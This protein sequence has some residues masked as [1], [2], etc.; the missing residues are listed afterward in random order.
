M[1]NRMRSEAEDARANQI[2]EQLR[3]LKRQETTPAASVTASVLGMISRTP[4]STSITSS[5]T[6]SVNC[7]DYDALS[8][9]ALAANI[10]GI[11][12]TGTPVDFQRLV[13]RFKDDGTSRTIV[14]TS[15]VF[16]YIGINFPTSTPIGKL[17]TVEVEHN[18]VT[19]KWGCIRK[20]V[21]SIVGTIY[22][23]TLDTDGN[24]W[25]G[26]TVL[27]RI[28]AA[29]LSLPSGTISQ[30]RVTVRA[31]NAEGLTISNLYVGHSNSSG[32]A[33]DYG[34]TPTALLFGGSA[35]KAIAAGT[36]ET[37][38]LASFSYNKT[39]DLIFAMNINGGTGSD[40]FRYK[41]G[42]GASINNYYKAGALEAATVNKS[43][44]TT[45]SGYNMGIVKIECDGF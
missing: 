12:I 7:D 1:F 17:M 35:S 23:Q 22:T 36:E 20:T 44:Y 13:F 2:E 45:N 15:S 24:N 39:D 3:N 31:G 8:V 34:A 29:A 4:R 28:G 5:A 38:D 42:L 18:I 16:E 6:P 30:L 37:C 19:G 40:T 33:F 11:S 41:T 32:D 21:E 14:W 43:G 9:T 10:T 25:N 26:Y 27:T